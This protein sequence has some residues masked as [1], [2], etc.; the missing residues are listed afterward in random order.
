MPPWQAAYRVDAGAS[1]LRAA[2]LGRGLATTR[3][4]AGTCELSLGLQAHGTQPAQREYQAL[5]I[6][7]CHAREESV[8]PFA[9]GIKSPILKRGRSR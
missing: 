5:P 9:D 4:P 1:I 3:A 7:S 6:H 2:L 8:S